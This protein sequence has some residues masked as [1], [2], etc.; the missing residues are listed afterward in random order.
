[1]CLNI[2]DVNE[3]NMRPISN[4]EKIN[5][6]SKKNYILNQS[7]NNY[8]QKFNNSYIPRNISFDFKFDFFDKINNNKN[9][10]SKERLNNI[11]L[12]YYFKHFVEIKSNNIRSLLNEKSENKNDLC[13]YSKK[14]I[15]SDIKFKGEINY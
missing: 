5:N 6:L 10:R 8:K 9:S 15:C 7:E 12:S 11:Y 3:L 14:N 2:A 13:L 1:M 4:I